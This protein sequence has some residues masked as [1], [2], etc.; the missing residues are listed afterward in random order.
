MT[1]EE[2]VTGSY[3]RELFAVPPT[4][5]TD[6]GNPLLRSRDAFLPSIPARGQSDNRCVCTSLRG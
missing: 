3:G 5:Q 6:D 4:N 2:G 1:K